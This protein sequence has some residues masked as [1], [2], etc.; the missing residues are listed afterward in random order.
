[1]SQYICYFYSGKGESLKR[2]C[3]LNSSWVLGKLQTEIQQSFYMLCLKCRD[4]KDHRGANFDAN[5]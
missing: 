3:V 1:M 5:T 2:K 4:P